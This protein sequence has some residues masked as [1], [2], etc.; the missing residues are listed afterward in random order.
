MSKEKKQTR[1]NLSFNQT[2]DPG[3]AGLQKF[4]FKL[5]SKFLT[6]SKINNTQVNSRITLPFFPRHLRRDSRSDGRTSLR[7]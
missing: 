5:S 3:L 4:K 1:K 2:R 7:G 6:L